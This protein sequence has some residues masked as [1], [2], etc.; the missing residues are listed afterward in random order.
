MKKLD[1]KQ[2][3]QFVALCVLSSGVFGYFVMRMVTPSEAAASSASPPAQV[4]TAPKAAATDPKVAANDPKVAA[5]IV[6]AS[7]LPGTPAAGL[8][9]LTPLPLAGMRDPF[10]VGYVDPKIPLPTAPLPAPPKLITASTQI[11]RT[12]LPGLSVLPAPSAPDLPTGLTG[13]SVRPTRTAPT[14]PTIAAPPTPAPT[15]TVTGVLQT[16]TEK[17]AILRSGEARRIVRS[18]DFVDSTFRVADVTRSY[19]VLKHGTETYRLMLGGGKPSTAPTLPPTSV[20][21]PPTFTAPPKYSAPAAPTS[22]APTSAAPARRSGQPGEASLT[23]AGRS[24]S[25]LAALWL[26]KVPSAPVHAAEVQ[27]S[28]QVALRFF[29]NTQE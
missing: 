9:P 3:P 7:A 6:V 14:L 27:P 23:Q 19:V 28:N 8:A 18:G 10:V 5:P 29:D 20:S 15:W 21:G 24:L 11:G 4:A 1:K 2:I 25:H 17:M 26:N 13:F 16:D 12:N 22:A